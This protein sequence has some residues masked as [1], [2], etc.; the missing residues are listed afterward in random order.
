[1]PM[2]APGTR[3]HVE[4]QQRETSLNGYTKMAALALAQNPLETIKTSTSH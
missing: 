4:K 1:M 2:A 3:E